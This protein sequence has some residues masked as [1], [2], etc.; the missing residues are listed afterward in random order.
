[1]NDD[2]QLS[3][4]QLDSSLQHKAVEDFAA[5]YLPLFDAN[6]L[7]MMS[8]YDVASYMTDINEHLTYG[9]YMTKAQR[10]SDTVSFSF[11]AYVNLIDRLDQQYFTSGNRA[12]PWNEWLAA[13]F[14]QT[15]T[16]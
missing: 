1:M 10:L 16:S 8:N 4:T 7:E 3:I 5:F 11:T 14:A 2:A 15:A 12:L 13:K 9:R 6:N